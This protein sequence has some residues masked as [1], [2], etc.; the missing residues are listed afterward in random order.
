LH[1]ISSGLI[2][3]NFIFAIDYDGSIIIAIYISKVK[4]IIKSCGKLDARQLSCLSSQLW[5]A[6]KAAARRAR[7]QFIENVARQPRQ[8]R[9][10]LR[11]S[12]A[13]LLARAKSIQSGAQHS[14]GP[15][16]IGFMISRESGTRETRCRG[17]DLT[18]P[19]LC[20][21]SG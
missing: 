13:S 20:Y 2:G 16:N 14:L 19:V 9:G 10:G 4:F 21:F 11:P 1:F 8:L 12:R 17:R 5:K 7:Q 6:D 18:V 15:D 3:N